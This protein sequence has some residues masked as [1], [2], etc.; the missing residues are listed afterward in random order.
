MP[1]IT[2]LP[3]LQWRAADPAVVAGFLRACDKTRATRRVQLALFMAG[4]VESNLQ[5]LKGGDLDSVG[6]LQQRAGWGTVAQRRNPEAA[7]VAFIHDAQR[8]V[9]PA[10]PEY[11]AAAVARAVQR[12]AARYLYRYRLAYPAARYVLDRALRE[13]NEA[14]S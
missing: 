4:I 5:N 14:H 9:I 8:R 7:A 1:L 2:Y 13:R 3:A 12:S 6:P 10:H 11:K